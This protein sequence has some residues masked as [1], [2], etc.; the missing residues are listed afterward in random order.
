MIFFC[1]SKEKTRFNLNIFNFSSNDCMNWKMLT[2]VSTE[3]KQLTLMCQGRFTGDPA[4]VFEV[5]AYRIT[6]ENTANEKFEEVKVNQVVEMNRNE[7]LVI[8]V[9]QV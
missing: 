6:N 5:T 2:P 3:A 9:D 4:N 7:I 1:N 8:L